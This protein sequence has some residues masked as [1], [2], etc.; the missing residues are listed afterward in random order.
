MRKDIAGPEHAST[1]PTWDTL[2]RMVRE[3]AQEFIQHILEEEVTELL[4]REKSERRAAVDALAGYRNGYGKPRRLA[5]SSGTITVRRPR[6]RGV[7]ERFESRVLP[8]F[9]RRTKEVGALIP[10]LYLHGLAEGDFE[11]AL[12]G[13]LGDGAPLSKSSIGRLRQS[14]TEEFEA[15][16]TRSLEGHEIVYVWPD[17]IYVKAGLERY[18]AALL[19]VIGAHR[20]GTKEVLALSS[21][22]RESVESWSE[23]FRDLKA[24]GIG[25]P[26]LL[27]ADG[28]AAIWGA[29]RQIWPKA[30]EQRCWNHKIRN[31]L[32]RLPKR[33]QAEA[34]DLLRKVV[35]AP[36]RADAV[37]ARQ[38]FSTRYNPWYPKA[39]DVLED[40]WDRVS[41]FYDFPEAHWKH[42][43]TTNIVES[44]FASVR[45]RTSAA[46]W[47][48]KVESATALIWKLLTVAK[49]VSYVQSKC[50]GRVTE[51][52]EVGV[53][54]DAGRTPG[55]RATVGL[56][57]G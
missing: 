42:L 48:K 49:R 17:G 40:D 41:A 34:K 30:G 52:N 20:D 14:W 16:S 23:V 8:L 2:E 6:V 53:G 37:K 57:H 5:M 22:Y 25:A 7:E 38:A 18:K 51:R 32:D 55:R 50:G 43:R 36:T 10:E 54:C 4:S 29:A 9:A 19:V 47:F 21:G 45:H 13:L 56:N 33:E 15:W 31:V 28:N 46:K 24:R 1:T 44:P 12:R 11:L 3:K 39:V 26:R 27:V 35:Y